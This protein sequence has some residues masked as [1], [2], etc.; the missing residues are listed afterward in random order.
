M[1]K[2]V[3][4]V[5]TLF[6][7]LLV[8]CSSADTNL[9][10]YD[11]KE[12]ALE[13][14]LDSEGVD[15]TAVL[16]IEKFKGETIVF[17]ELNGGLGVASIAESEKGFSWYRNKPYTGFE[18][19]SPYSV[20]GLNIETKTG[21][22]IFI[23]AGKAFDTS[24]E[25]MRLVGDGTEKELEVLGKSRLFYSVHEAPFNSLEVTPI[26][27]V[28][29]EQL[30]AQLTEK[31][32]KM[33]NADLDKFM[34]G[35]GMRKVIEVPQKVNF[36][37]KET[38][39]E[40][41]DLFVSHEFYQ[42]GEFYYL[43]FTVTSKEVYKEGQLEFSYDNDELAFV[44]D[45]FSNNLKLHGGNIVSRTF[46]VTEP[47]NPLRYGLLLRKRSEHIDNN[48]I[49]TLFQIDMTIDREEFMITQPIQF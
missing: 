23:L 42:K 48:F 4:L 7:M 47:T 13:H 28:N 39:K 11:T 14:G 27:Q 29:I 10:W 19:D 5:L 49:H 38:S 46:T 34:Q 24:I 8:G 44:A 40:I 33:S 37:H 43:E 18:G 15:K 26:W 45:N 6:L 2:V 16:S 9:N 3:F 36:K 1:K 21:E 22:D 25:K 12:K 35:K 31:R 41:D 30:M 17:Y 32:A 20:L